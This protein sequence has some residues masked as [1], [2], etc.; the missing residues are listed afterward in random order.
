MK[1]IIC[2]LLVLVMALGL[3]AC[4]ESGNAKKDGLYVGFGRENITPEYVVHMAGGDW[5]SRTSNGFID[6]ICV[7]CVAFTEGDETLLF[8]T[9]D[10]LGAEDSFVDPAVAA[11]AEATGVPAGNIWMNATHTHSSVGIAYSWDKTQIYRETFNKAAIKAAQTA[12]EDQAKSEVY[13]GGVQTEGMA[14]V[15]HYNMSGGS[16]AGANF[17]NFSDGTIVG[18]TVDA[19]T[20]LQLVNFVREGEDKKDILLMSFPAHCTM[21]QNSQALSADYPAP[22]RTYVEANSNTLVAFWQGASGDQVPSSR[23]ASEAYSTDYRKFGERL[24]QYA[25]DAIPT[26][27]KQESADLKFA[28]QTYVGQSNKEKIDR[29][30]D[31]QAVNAVINQYSKSSAEAKAAASQYGFSSVYEATS[32]ISRANSD[33]TK[34]MELRVFSLGEVGFVLAPY[35]MFCKHSMQIKEES[36]FAETFIATLGHGNEGYLPTLQAFEYDSYEACVTS[37][38]RGTGEELVGKYV[39][40]LKGLQSAE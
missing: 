10:F 23:I 31:A 4:S 12:I 17:G 20:E 27:T 22:A 21:N 16:V 36:P 1:R 18:H 32:I 34:E 37:Y 5:K 33:D 6:Q 8:Y 3:C 9:M 2:I 39:E 11:I 24:G 14:F 38:A 19:D 13:Y 25:I 15:R 40:M 7:T 28:K 26:L 29:L 30:A 35:E